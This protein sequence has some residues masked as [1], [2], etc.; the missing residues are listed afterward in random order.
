MSSAQ[1]EEWWDSF[2]SNS[3]SNLSVLLLDLLCVLYKV[4]D[5]IPGGLIGLFLGLAD[6]FDRIL[7]HTAPD[8]FVSLRVDNISHDAALSVRISPDIGS[9]APTPTRAIGNAVS[10]PEPRTETE[11]R[12][13]DLG[14]LF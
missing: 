10:P 1:R 8:E 4:F 5:Q 13:F 14:L 3:T 7:Y 12:T 9:K 6:P 2:P 11:A